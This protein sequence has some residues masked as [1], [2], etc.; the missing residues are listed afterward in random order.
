V[1]FVSSS[2]IFA[3]RRLWHLLAVIRTLTFVGFAFFFAP[4]IVLAA[5]PSPVPGLEDYVAAGMKAF[6]VPGVAIGI[7]A[8]DA[9]VYRQGFGVRSKS[10]G[11][12]VTA[13]TVFQIASTSK[14]FLAASLAIAVDRSKLNW[15]DRVVDL[16]PGFQLADPW[17]TRELRVYDV[18]A[19][20]SGLPGLA[21]DILGY[22]GYDANAMVR[23]LRYV[24]PA[25]SFRSSF[26]YTNITHTVA[27]RLVADALGAPD[28]GTVLRRDLFDPLAMK[29]SSY[30]RAAIEAAPNHA[31]GHR[32]ASQGSVEIPF[33][34]WIPYRWE[35]AGAVNSTVTDMTAWL[36][37][38][39]GNG[40]FEGKS[41][42]SAANLAVTRTP[43]V[44]IGEKA[45]Y[46]MGWV[47]AQTPKGA[48]V[49]HNGATDGFGAY[50][51]LDLDRKLAVVVLTN[52]AN[53]GFPD[54][55]G[56]WIFDAVRGN[57]PVDHVT[58]AL[59]R[60]K[61][62]L[63]EQARIWTK[64]GNPRPFPPLAPLAGNFTSPDFGKATLGLSD[65]ALVLTL[66][67]SGAE[68]RLEPWDGDIF[69]VNLLPKGDFSAVVAG[70][71]GSLGFAQVQMGKNGQLDTLRMTLENGQ[72]YEL[73]RE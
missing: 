19:Q 21:N 34:D 51:A 68:L 46:A 67:A 59:E 29:S 23:S 50:V 22:L 17:V 18:I 32:Y 48:I 28:W 58:A 24:E 63:A 20:R 55:I 3:D 41:I 25:S 15:N 65:N 33:T 60:A 56:A 57:P 9:V 39:L 11:E 6:D 66:Q 47:V 2:N 43:K 69:S 37:M 64:P 1:S 61:A 38:Q 5:D 36:R 70:H 31:R 14:A 71:G 54:A 42:V 4:G 62:D 10:G 53:V 45:S 13:D 16:M 26:T 40:T 52:E 49:L 72:T 8:Q 7:V 30:T 73:R 44:A 35:G 12:P 27:S